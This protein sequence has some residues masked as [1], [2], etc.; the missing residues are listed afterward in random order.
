VDVEAAEQALEEEQTVPALLRAAARLLVEA[1]GAHA[2]AVS[3]LVGELIVDM[4]NFTRDGR[5]LVLGYGYLVSDFPLTREVVERREPRTVA[6]DDD[7]ADEKE[8]ALL[9]ELGYASLLMLPLER[10]G[11]SWGLVELYHLAGGRFVDG[12]VELARR[13]VLRT[14]ELLE[15]IDAPTPS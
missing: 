11:Q 5:S 14:A 4:A 1:T 15:R 10:A 9:N 7:S 13:L 6:L 8:V 12:D 3:R 2:A